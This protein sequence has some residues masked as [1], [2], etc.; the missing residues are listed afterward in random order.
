MG[1]LFGRGDELLLV[2]P[3]KY[4]NCSGEALAPLVRYFKIEPDRVVVIHDDVDLQTGSL[5]VKRGGGAGGQHGVEDIVNHLGTPEFYRVR[6]GV[7]RAPGSLPGEDVSSWVLGEPKGE[8]R[9]TLEITAKS[10]AECALTITREGLEAA[11]QKYSR[12][13]FHLP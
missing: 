12:K 10:A 7:G 1:C 11:S 3:Q 9:S 8:E 13:N 6:I 5:R 4:M 2:K